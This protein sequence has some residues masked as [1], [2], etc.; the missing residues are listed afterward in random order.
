MPAAPHGRPLSPSQSRE[1]NGAAADEGRRCDVLLAPTEGDI[2]EDEEVHVDEACDEIEPIRHAADPGTPTESQVEEHRKTH[3]PFRSWC[4]WC[5]LGRGR[6]IVHTKSPHASAPVLGIDYFFLTKGG[7][8]KRDELEYPADTAGEEALEAARSS[9]DIVKC[10]IIRCFRNKVIFGHV[11]PKKGLDEQGVAC[12]HVLAALEWLGY[13]RVIIKSDNEPAIRALAAR[14]VEL[15]KVE[16]KGME[17]VGSEQSAAYDSQSNG[18]TEVGIRLIRGMFRTTKLC[19]ESRI[20]KYVPI[21]HPV[22]P[23]MLE[24]VCLLLNVLV[25]GEDGITPWQRVR[26]RPFN[27]RLLGFGESVLYRYPSKGPLSQ[28][29]GNT[30]ALGAE[31]SFMGYS[32]SSNTFRVVG[33]DSRIVAARSMTRRSLA[34]RWN[35]KALADIR[36]APGTGY[37][38]KD[39]SQVRFGA[40]PT[41]DGPTAEET[42]QA[43]NRR[44]RINQSDLDE[45]GYFVSCLQCAHI[46]RHGR[47]RPG[48]THSNACRDRIIEALKLT[49]KGRARLE[50][51]D[52]RVQRTQEERLTGASRAV[53]A[54]IP[55]EAP[56]GFLERAPGVGETAAERAPVSAPPAVHMGPRD[57]AAERQPRALDSAADQKHGDKHVPTVT[58]VP[59]GVALPAVEAT[60]AETLQP[61]DAG[62]NEDMEEDKHDHDGD[63]MDMGFVGSFEVEDRLGRLEPNF[64]DEVSALLLNQMGSAGR[65]YKRE[66][67]QAARKI[68]SEVYS[69]PRVTKLIREARMR[70]VMPGYALDLTTNDPVDGLPWDFSRKV[71]RDRARKILREQKPYMLI[72]SPQCKEFCTWQRLN[73]ARHPDNGE[74]QAARKAAEAHLRFVSLLYKDQHDGGRYFLHEH[75]RWATSWSVRAIESISQLPGVQTVHGDQCQYGAETQSSDSISEKGSPILKPTGFMTNAP[76]VAQALSRRCAGVGG[77]CSRPEGGIHRQ[78]SGKHAR[79]AQ[80]YPRGLCRAILRGVRD[81]MREDRLLREGCFGVQ[82]PDDDATVEA[83]LRGPSSGY[84]GRYRD[85][86]TGQVLKDALVVEARAKEL[87]FFCSKGVW[88]KTPKAQARAIS[89]RPAISVRWVDVN[90]G[91]DMN[92]NYRSRLV[93]RQIKAQDHS[94]KSYFAP[95]PPLEALR[96]VLSLAMTKVGSHVP[97]WDAMSTRRTQISRVDIKRAY[98]NAKIDPNDPPTFVQLPEEDPD[99]EVMV[100]RLLRHMYGTR[101]AADGWQEEYSTALISFGFTQGDACPNLFYHEEKGIVTSVHGDDFTS[102]GPA[103]SL[104]WLEQSIGERYEVTIEPRLGPGP[105]DAKEGRVLNRVIRWCA[106]SIEYEADPRQ[107]ERL[108]SECGLAGAQSMATPGVKVGFAELE[109]DEELS[110]HLTTAFRGSA[111]RGNYLSADRVDSQ[112]A[113][114]EVCRW[115]SK[116][117]AQAWKALKRLCRFFNGA[118]RMVYSFQKQSVSSTD[119]YVDTDWA[120][121]PKTRKSTSGGCV[122]FGSHCVKHWSSTQTSIALSSGEAEFAGVLRGAGQGLGYQALLKDLGVVVPLRVWTDSAAAIGICNRQG[123]GK[124]RHL[125]THTLWIQQAVRTGRVDLRKVLGEENPADL[126]TKHSLSRQRLEKLIPLFGCRYLGGRAAAAPQMRKGESSRVTMA[127]AQNDAGDEE[128]AELQEETSPCMPHLTYSAEELDARYPPLVAPEDDGLEDLAD[129]GQDQVYQHGLGIA[130]QIRADVAVQGR[131]RRPEASS[132]AGVSFVN[133]T[134]ASPRLTQSEAE[135]SSA[136]QSGIDHNHYPRLVRGEVNMST[137]QDDKANGVSASSSR[138]KLSVEE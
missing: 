80:K 61:K 135:G 35:A 8:V 90:K 128:V 23:W 31:G 65:S 37:T 40:R 134:T 53:E 133:D 59:G 114:K 3:M 39:R 100:A 123:L 25:R 56:R 130:R 41:V 48:A 45:H 82:V 88:L 6:G 103:D 85:D 71:K 118:P 93:A 116:P 43:V 112:F 60:R 94:G 20:G 99:S 86:L 92:E 4:R 26:M 125:D 87:A 44:L 46:Q 78:C 138:S 75:P 51:Q 55:E 96:T 95:A 97:D 107:V 67:S 16:C 121:C 62:N 58:G 69:P 81:Q 131:R 79:E 136:T 111:A 129:D 70:H 64:D 76:K 47:P 117:T 21:D 113:C 54:A 11:V 19:L 13:S 72:G 10:L 91:D 120:G 9:G 115:M 66:R 73:E 63:D 15:A 57:E 109:A 27:Q 14:V 29:D 68:V 49:D 106:D 124:L 52:E 137:V 5:V 127:E 38:P 22:I 98:F 33:A 12:D 77:S 18:G 104:D 110:P 126:L 83:E 32:T 34:E 74:R 30:G 132:G 102:S 108:V 2:G 50:L 101:M 84:S 42:R 17:Q 28:P 89:G 7:A 1:A 122:M 36:V 119:V 24:H 105:T